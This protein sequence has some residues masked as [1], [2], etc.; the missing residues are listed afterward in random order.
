MVRPGQSRDARSDSERSPELLRQPEICVDCGRTGCVLARAAATGAEPLAR[1]SRGG[2]GI[3]SILPRP[4]TATPYDSRHGT[5]LPT[6]WLCSNQLRCR[7]TSCR[8][9]RHCSR[10][11][12]RA[13]AAAT[14]SSALQGCRGR[15]GMPKQLQDLR[16]P[17][18]LLG[19]CTCARRSTP[20]H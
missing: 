9:A 4:H 11:R 5:H 20:T 8:V 13:A 12:A 6:G 1:G 7:R 18:T 15:C 17:L 2:A 14:S 16:N 19:Q 10:R 3:S